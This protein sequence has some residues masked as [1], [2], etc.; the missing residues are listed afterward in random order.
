MIETLNSLQSVGRLNL[1]DISHNK[2]TEMQ[3]EFFTA[4]LKLIRLNLSYNSLSA[5]D[6]T[7][8][9]QLA[10]VRNSVDLNGNP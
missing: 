2:L 7:V 4:L 6:I 10:I 1:L 5:L 3:S 9:P 8:M